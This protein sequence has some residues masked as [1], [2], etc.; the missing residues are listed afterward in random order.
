MN[1]F[2]TCRKALFFMCKVEVSYFIVRYMYIYICIH[3]IYLYTRLTRMLYWNSREQFRLEFSFNQITKY[4]FEE[5]YIYKHINLT[6]YNDIFVA[7]GR[8]LF[9]TRVELN[10]IKILQREQ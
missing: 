1:T 7:T 4:I 8:V 2:S 5:I 10:D 9:E 6:N 3:N